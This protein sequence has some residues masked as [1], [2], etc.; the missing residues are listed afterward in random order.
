MCTTYDSRQDVT[1]KYE[2]AQSTLKQLYKLLSSTAGKIR[3]HQNQ[4][5]L[6]SAVAK[7]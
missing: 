6:P 5:A 4:R 2:G 3:F 1:A 7:R